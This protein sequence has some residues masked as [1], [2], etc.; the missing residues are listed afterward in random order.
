MTTNIECD[1]SYISSIQEHPHTENLVWEILWE[2]EQD[3]Y[4]PLST[5]D[6]TEQSQLHTSREA[7]SISIAP[8]SYFEELKKQHF[9][10]AT[11]KATHTLIGFLSYRHGYESDET[12]QYSPSNY[13]TT[14]C[15]RKSMRNRGVANQLF[16]F[17]EAEIP[18]SQQLPFITRRTWS[19]NYNQLSLYEKYG[20]TCIHRILNDRDN[21][22]DT[23]YYAKRLN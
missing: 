9:L 8:L 21:G 4:P 14:T 11:D 7:E 18:Q 12:I 13:I 1:I 3:F 17:M 16:A 19:T 22:V 20:Y 23:L 2:C 6:S 5:R 10:L 15:V